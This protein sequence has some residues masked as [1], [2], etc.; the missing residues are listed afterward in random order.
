L[1][2]FAIAS[3]LQRPK[4]DLGA[5]GGGFGVHPVGSADHHRVAMFFGQTDQRFVEIDERA[6]DQARGVAQHR[7]PR[8]VDHI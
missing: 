5:E 4:R 2:T 8:G 7:A 3:N 1:H 6:I